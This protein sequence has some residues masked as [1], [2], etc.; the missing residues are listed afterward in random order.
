MK[1]V[2]AGVVNARRGLFEEP[3]VC[4]WGLKSSMGKGQDENEM[5]MTADY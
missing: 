2:Q 4:W 3:E 1:L 5:R